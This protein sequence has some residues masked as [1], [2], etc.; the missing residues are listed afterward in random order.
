MT[1]EYLL[2]VDVGTSGSSG[3]IV[4]QDLNVIATDEVTHETNVP[5]PGWAEHDADAIWWHD[6]TRLST[7]LLERADV[8]ASDIAGVG[9]SALHTNM[10]PLD[11]DGEPLR[12]AILYGV[13]TRTGEEIDLLNDRI[14]EERIFDVCGNR[15]TFQSVGPKILWYKRNEPEKFDRTERILDATGYVVYKLTGEY[16]IDNANASFFHPLYDLSD[17]AWDDDMFD[18]VGISREL[19][20]E[21]QWASEIAG[22]VTDDA[23][24]ATGLEPGTPV[25]VGTGDS[26]ASLVGVAA[27]D[28]RDAI[29]MYGTTG[30]IY[31]TLAEEAR[32]ENL[33]SFPHCLEGKYVLGGGMATAGAVVRWFKEEFGFEERRQASAER[34]AYDLLNER[35]A[36]VDAGADG[37]V[38]VPYFSGERT[39]MN[40]DAARGLFAGVTLSHTKSHFYRAILEGVGYGFRHHLDEMA[41]A[42]VT[43][44]R[45]TAIGGGA[46][47][48]VWRQIVSDITGTTQE[49]VSNPIGAPLG[50]AY[51]AGLGTGVFT[52]LDAI[53]DATSVS[54]RTTPNTDHLDVYDDCYAVYRDLYPQTRESMHALSRVGE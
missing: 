21:P 34:D 1:T 12:P 30:I 26:I 16:T 50:D 7:R 28:D 17:L 14:G 53:E 27:V 32:A 9:V 40:D 18:E 37:L 38:M 24:E 33:W 3:A 43:P 25:V 46:R 31:T 39:P 6:F 22:E 15:L 11:E 5:R 20:P 49:Y 19:L 52:D 10:L 35:A 47:S 51:L 29:F 8:D 23:A 45:V 41:A 2:G 44:D 54:D 4:D 13:D 42:G 36:K 48:P